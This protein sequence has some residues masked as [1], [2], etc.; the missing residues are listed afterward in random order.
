MVGTETRVDEITQVVRAPGN[1]LES[2][3]I[4]SSYEAKK[5]RQAPRLELGVRQRITDD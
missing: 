4:L 1:T 5:P 2:E 3:S